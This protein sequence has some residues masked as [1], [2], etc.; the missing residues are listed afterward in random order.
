MQ[1]CVLSCMRA[2]T[3]SRYAA[4]DESAVRSQSIP[5]LKGMPEYNG[6]QRL[7]LRAVSSRERTRVLGSPN[8]QNKERTVIVRGAEVRFEGRKRPKKI[9]RGRR[10]TIEMR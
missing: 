5:E 3:K 6:P 1:D 8:G 9:S 4:F 10:K 7:R 2:K